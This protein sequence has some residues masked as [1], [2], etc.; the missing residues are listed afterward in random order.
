[1]CIVSIAMHCHPITYQLA[2]ADL[3]NYGLM[4]MIM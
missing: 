1:M 3:Q 2:V 4:I